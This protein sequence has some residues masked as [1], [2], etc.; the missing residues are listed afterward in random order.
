MGLAAAVKA[1]GRQG[2]GYRPP[3]GQPG[4]RPNPEP[5]L[6]VAALAERPVIPFALGESI[7][8][9]AIKQLS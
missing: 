7:L 8:G 6:K 3:A 4:A 9:L 5:L 2:H 1:Q